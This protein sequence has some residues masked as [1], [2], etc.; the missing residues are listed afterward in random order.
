M[1]FEGFKIAKTTVF[2]DEGVLVVIAAV[3]FGKLRGFAVGICGKA[4]REMAKETTMRM[5]GSRRFFKASDQS[6]GTR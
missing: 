2:I 3:L 1:L 6:S 5:D 4:P